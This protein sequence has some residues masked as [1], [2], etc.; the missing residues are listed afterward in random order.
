[1]KRGLRRM[2]AQRAQP[3]TGAERYLAERRRDPDYRSDYERACE[4]VDE[5]DAVIRILDERR[6]ELQLT[7]AELGRRRRREAGGDPTELSPMTWNH[8][9][10]KKGLRGFRGSG[11]GLEG[12]I[13]S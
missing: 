8:L 3:R 6:E 10:T 13:G 2:A 7:K 1:M 12:V 11:S 5:V 4:R 9:L